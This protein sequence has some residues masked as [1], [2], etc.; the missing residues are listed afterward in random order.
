MTVFIF[1]GCVVAQDLH[2]TQFFNS[3]LNTNPGLTGVFNGD[4]RFGLHYKQQWKSVPVDYLTFSGYADKKFYGKNNDKGFFSAG[5]LF[6]YDRAGDSRMTL[7]QGALSATYTFILNERNLITVGPQ[8][9]VSNM[10]A[11]FG[12]DLAFGN[13]WTGL[14]FDATLGSGEP[15][16]E[17]ES[18]TYFDLGAG[19]NYRW[20]KSERTHIDVGGGFYNITSPNHSFY[21]Y[22]VTSDLPLRYSLNASAWIQLSDLLDVWGHVLFQFQ[23]VNREYVPAV[24]VRLHINRKRGSQFALDIGGVARMNNDHVDSW[25]PYVAFEFN[26]FFLGLSYDI[27]DSD[28]GDNVGREG[29]PEISFR[30][31][32]K[33]VKPLKNFKNCP[34]F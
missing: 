32:L 7:L 17:K 6:N 26:Q 16:D 21:D 14:V 28:F 2:F 30:Y 9:G 1:S 33:N 10:S 11:N 23:D 24:G 27:T 20:Q 13:Q 18:V 34:I 15:F 31:I 5:I 3:P 29:G 25:N 4:L 22:D 8:L 19:I 12:D